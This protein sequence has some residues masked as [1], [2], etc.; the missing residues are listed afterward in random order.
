MCNVHQLRSSIEFVAL[1]IADRDGLW[2]TG[3]GG[4]PTKF[5]QALNS[6]T[7]ET[8]E[9]GDLDE[10]MQ[11]SHDALSAKVHAFTEEILRE[12][13]VTNDKLAQ[14]ISTIRSSLE[15]QVSAVDSLQTEL[16]SKA[17][18]LAELEDNIRV[19]KDSL[20][21][22]RARLDEDHEQFDRQIQTIEE[23]NKIGKCVVTLNVGG[24]KYETSILTLTKD[25]HSMLAA[26]FSGR[27]SLECKDDGCYFID[28]D[29]THFRYVLNYLRDGGM[30]FEVPETQSI[31]KELRTEAKY[32]QLNGLVD[33]LS[34]HIV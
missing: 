34:A 15:M 25:P 20:K 8:K 2:H 32:Y 3:F 12:A 10:V 11:K 23:V 29:G 21:V 5:I 27:H 22:K 19:E 4:E 31:L 28:R 13:R 18:Q 1:E 24:H 26:M 33:L 17:Q 16:N 14:D 9:K 7:K 30:D 6:N